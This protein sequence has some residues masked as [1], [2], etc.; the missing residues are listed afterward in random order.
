MDGEGWDERSGGIAIR[1]RGFYLRYR[2][3]VGVVYW[4]FV[5]DGI[6]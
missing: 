6:W 2:G 3:S 1:R 4:V 5:S